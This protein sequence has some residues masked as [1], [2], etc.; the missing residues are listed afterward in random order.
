MIAAWQYDRLEV[1]AKLR[2]TFHIDKFRL[3]SPQH[4]NAFSIIFCVHEPDRI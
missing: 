1:F 3:S 2:I 4:L